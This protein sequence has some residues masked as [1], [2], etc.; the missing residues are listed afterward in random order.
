MELNFLPLVNSKFEIPVFRRR[1]ENNKLKPQGS[2]GFRLKD[3]LSGDYE[4]FDVLWE[5]SEGFELYHADSFENHD[6]TKLY[7]FSLM[8]SAAKKITLNVI[9][10]RKISIGKFGLLP[11]SIKRVKEKFDCHHIIF[12]LI[13]N[14]VLLCSIILK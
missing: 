4:R 7:I 2:F 12:Q 10:R 9:H 11:R 14:L 8:E 3:G 5:E 1:S 6:L 13:S